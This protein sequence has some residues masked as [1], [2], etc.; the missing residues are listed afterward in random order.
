MESLF[1]FVTILLSMGISL[2]VGAST[3]AI[4]NFFVAIKD[5][6]IEETER[7]FM[8]ITYIVLRVAMV[9]ILFSAATLAYFG[10]SNMGA[11]Y[12]NNYAIAQFIV[13]GILYMNAILMT[14]RVM[15]STFGPAVQASSWYTLGFLSA[16][17]GLGITGFTMTTFF[18]S[19]LAIFILAVIL[20][21]GVMGHLKSKRE[22]KPVATT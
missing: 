22:V 14:L 8:G 6:K 4:L 3:M 7:H 12:F 5:G 16:F 13:I 2:G 18:L 15:P 21:N 1:I 9:I 20:I 10:A 19:Y 17:Y 11:L